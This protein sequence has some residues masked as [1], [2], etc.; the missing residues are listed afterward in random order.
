VI[1]SITGKPRRRS[2][3][4]PKFIVLFVLPADGEG[5]H[6]SVAHLPHEL[7]QDFRLA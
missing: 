1:L 7:E 3:L 6:S 4:R 5:Q 2:I